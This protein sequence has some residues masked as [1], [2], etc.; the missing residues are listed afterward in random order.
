VGI[1]KLPQSTFAL[2]L[3]AGVGVYLL[4]LQ[5]ISQ[6]A[7]LNGECA[8]GLAI[9]ILAQFRSFDALF[10]IRRPY[11]GRYEL[12]PLFVVACVAYVGLPWC[13][14]WIQSQWMG[15]E[16]EATELVWLAMLQYAALW[17]SAFAWNSRHEWVSF[18][19]SC[20]IVIFSLASSDRSGMVLLV[21]VFGVMA[22][23][24]LMS[25]YWKGFASGGISNQSVPLT[26]LRF[27]ALAVVASFTCLL[28]TLVLAVKT[29]TTALDGFMPTSGG[30]QWSDPNARQGVGDGDM[31]VAAK[32]K[33]YTFGPV[34]SELFLESKMPSLYDLSSEIYGEPTVRKDMSRTI[35]LD[36]KLQESHQEA[37]ESKRNS[38]E[39]SAL[40]QSTKAGGE[41]RPKETKSRAVLQLIGR[42]PQRL[43]LE[44][45]DDFDG[46][47]WTQSPG[48]WSRDDSSPIALSQ[49]G[50]KPW[51]QV[52]SPI[53]DL[54]HPIQERLAIKI[55]GLKS[56]RL[57][58]PSLISH[59]HIDRVD[60]TS[61]FA[62]SDDGML[63]MPGRDHVPQMTV[64]HQLYRLPRLHSLRDSTQ[65]HSVL[66]PQWN[67]DSAN[68]NEPQTDR[69]LGGDHYPWQK[70]K[71]QCERMIESYWKRP[72]EGL[73][74]WQRIEGVVGCLRREFNHDARVKA[75]EDCDDVVEFF[76]DRKV[77]P[78]Y[79][80]ATTA[81]VFVR[82]M[83]IPCRLVSG[84]YASPS[85]YDIKSGQTEVL[86]EDL[87]TWAE[88]YCHG[89]WIPIEPTP[90]YAVPD[91]FRTWDQFAREAM[92]HLW[93]SV[94]QNYL[95]CILCFVVLCAAYFERRLLMDLVFSASLFLGVFGSTQRVVRR[96]VRLLEWRCWIYGYP[97]SS[98]AT[99]AKWLTQQLQQGSR[100]TS[101]DR[102]AFVD[103]VDR[104]AYAPAK[105]IQSADLMAQR[106][107][108]KICWSIAK[109]QWTNASTSM[110]AL[111]N[112]TRYL[113]KDH[114]GL[115]RS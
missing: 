91:E 52:R 60:Q 71:P 104:I 64:V 79:L 86:P 51:I 34:D 31:L 76:L 6:P 32:D 74:D 106:R 24:W 28:G 70:Y 113:F 2:T 42:V 46:T 20:F 54:T 18:L 39:F 13:R 40:R 111:L 93:G 92:W 56:S 114:K 15:G 37:T 102:R 77:G 1:V 4:R 3:L 29:S 25:Q 47:N 33:A 101:H 27:F 72:L 44:T 30:N 99:T 100:L 43:R 80:F 67:H 87:H 98:F 65:V 48:P 5:G 53:H 11:E 62:M 108:R 36:S 96:T 49:I 115:S 35:A 73:T 75:P 63:M 107:L 105:S 55:I 38:K 22:A 97:R 9:A 50:G 90:G 10:G 68:A 58:T 16:G 21:A 81:V 45:Y 78:D 23:W 14:K 112:T 17:Q 41:F 110:R 69:Y 12:K 85:N 7:W 94:Q 66:T 89:V 95:A 82:S 83:G 19:L 103:A 8:L 26:R 59:V 57:L 88:V 84:F 109:G 61:F